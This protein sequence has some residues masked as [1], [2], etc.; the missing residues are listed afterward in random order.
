MFQ[1]DRVKEK[2]QNF[3]GDIYFLCESKV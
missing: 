2:S 3:E 1:Q